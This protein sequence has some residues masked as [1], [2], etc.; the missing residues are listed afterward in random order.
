MSYSTNRVPDCYFTYRC[1]D[2]IEPNPNL[3]SQGA[4]RDRSSWPR[5]SRD[6]LNFSGRNVRLDLHFVTEEKKKKRKRKFKHRIIELLDMVQSTVGTLSVVWLCRKKRNGI[7]CRFL[8]FL[9]SL[10][11]LL[12][13]TGPADGKKMR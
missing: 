9:P 11:T 10:A 4:P 3:V 12:Y 7:G 6:R 13:S 1:L 2:G 5:Q 8:F